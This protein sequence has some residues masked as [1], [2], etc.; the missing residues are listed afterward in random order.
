MP[1]QLGCPNCDK[2]FA[3][4]DAE[5][6]YALCPKCGHAFAFEERAV[7]IVL[8]KPTNTENGNLATGIQTGPQESL[9]SRTS[10]AD[11]DATSA[12]S[13]TRG[14]GELLAIFGIR[15]SSPLGWVGAVIIFFLPWV[16]LR[17]FDKKGEVVSHVSC[18]GHQLAWGGGTDLMPKRDEEEKADQKKDDGFIA[19]GAIKIAP[20]AIKPT[21][22]ESAASVLLSIYAAGLAFGLTLKGICIMTPPSFFR[23]VAGASYSLCLLFLPLA[24]MWVLWG[25]PLYPPDEALA[26]LEYTPWYYAC[27]AANLWA[28]LSFGLEFWFVRKLHSQYQ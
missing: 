24:G 21:S 28:V 1:I 4:H 12:Q 14:T 10:P 5:G 8:G 15:L 27:Y 7:G 17:C 2:T 18:S 11:D 3:L 16:E 9:P 19:P 26:I 20:D 25:N 23:A 13:V 6:E 22:S